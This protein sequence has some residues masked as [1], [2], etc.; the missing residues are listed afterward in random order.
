MSYSDRF[1]ACY[2]QDVH[3]EI[4]IGLLTDL[5]L[6]TG[7]SMTYPGID[8]V[9]LLSDYG[10]QSF[11]SVAEFMHLVTNEP[12]V[13][14][15]YWWDDS[16]DLYC[17]VQQDGGLVSVEFALDGTSIT[18]EQKVWECLKRHFVSLAHESFALILILDRVGR[19]SD[20][21][22]KEIAL[23]QTILKAPYPDEMIIPVTSKIL[24]SVVP[25]YGRTVQLTRYSVAIQS[26]V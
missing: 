16:D 17:R 10:D 12:L 19:T 8:S 18:Q 26:V 9:T 1:S 21:N 15:Q 6:N 4:I 23:G 3:A 14:F 2:F 5:A 25:A 24:E 13:R 22:W 20:Y 11:V 7:M